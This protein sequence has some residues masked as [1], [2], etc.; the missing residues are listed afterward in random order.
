MSAPPATPDTFLT[1]G[2]DAGALIRAHDWAAT[3]LGPIET[4]PQSLR[5]T[6]SIVLNSRFPTYMGWGPDLLSFYNDAYRPILGTKP[7]AMGRPFREVWAEAWAVVGPIARQALNGEASYHENLPITVDRHGYPEETWWTFCYSPIRDETGGVGGVLCTVYETTGQVRAER[8]RQAEYERLQQLFQQAPGFMAV[9]RGPNHIFDSANASYLQLIGHRDVLGRTVREALPEVASQGFLELLDRVYS[10]GEPFVGHGMPVMLQRE[11]GGALEQRLVDFVY[12]PIKDADGHVTGIFAEGIDVTER[13]LAEEAVRER[14]D[15]YRHTVELNPQVTWTARPD[16][17]LDYVNQRWESWTGTS[18]LG[19]IWCDALHPDDRGPT[20][21]AWTHA[22][23]TGE[24]YDSEH[25]VRTR[26]GSYRWVHSRARPRR[27]ERGEIVKWYG[28]TEDIDERKQAEAAL[29]ANEARHRQIINSATDYAIISKDLEGRILSWNEGARRILGWTEEEI[30]GQ[31][32]HRYFTPEDVAAGQVEQEMRTALRDGSSPDE[33]WHLRR[34]GSRF[35]AT[36]ELMPLRDDA[37]AVV[38]FVKVLRDATEQRR[39]GEH[40]RLLINELNHRVKNT[41]ATVQSIA[42]QTLRNADTAEGAR[43]AIEDR[44]M[45]LSRAHDVLTR[46][47]WEG[48]NLHEIVAQA[49]APYSSRGEDRLHLRGEPVRLPP[50]MAL[51]LAMALQ[52]LATNAVK[53]G[54]L[55]NETGQVRI[56]WRDGDGRLHLTW[57]EQGGPPVKAPSRRGFGTRLIERS[58]ASDLDG[59]VRIAFEPSGLVCTVDAPLRP[60]EDA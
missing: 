1:H 58:L 45:A 18:G 13:R 49:V 16:G 25:R 54:A 17:Q 36:G 4:W 30:L 15:H 50:R 22:F 31:T 11:A 55:S 5:T 32:A 28:T 7:E 48:A 29:L 12:Q 19:S 20:M 9:L 53:Y 57:T 44:L 21:E 24:P 27:N 37:G 33:R 60:D 26:A 2:G 46:E 52:E 51:A 34:D 39:A 59:E 43:E 56:A 3:P 14:E 6:L 8:E 47:N 42:S 40:Q 41:L 23:T 10:S 35:W 38:G